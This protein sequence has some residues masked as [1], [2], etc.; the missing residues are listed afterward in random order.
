MGRGWGERIFTSDTA[1]DCIMYQI[2]DHSNSG[3]P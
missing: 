1:E 2:P 3:P